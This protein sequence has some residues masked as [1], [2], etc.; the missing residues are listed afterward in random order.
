MDGAYLPNGDP[1]RVGD[2]LQTFT[3]RCFWPLDPRPE[4]ICIEDIAHSLSLRCR[5][6]GH[7]T[8][9]YSV[10]EHSVLVSLRVPRQFALWGLLHDAAE[11]YTADVPRPLKRNLPDWKPIEARIMAMVCARFGLPPEEPDAVNAVDLAITGD[12]RVA[13]MLPCARDWGPLP[14]PLGVEVCGMGPRRAEKAF[15]RRFAELVP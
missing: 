12:E 10:A 3:G 5:Y 9:F 15:L 7:V 6:G 1:T 4:E 2:W 14:P 8:R 13:L 11:A